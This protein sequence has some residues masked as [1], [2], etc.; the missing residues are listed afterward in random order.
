MTADDISVMAYKDEAPDN[1]ALTALEWLLWY[2]LRDCYKRNRSDVDAGRREKAQILKQFSIDKDSWGRTTE[3]HAVL[4]GWWKRLEPF[5][6]AYAT[7]PSVETADSLFEALY[8]VPR[9]KQIEKWKE[10]NRIE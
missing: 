3:L 10:A 4:A 7:N 5:A 8:G 9:K 1:N 2:R 6:C